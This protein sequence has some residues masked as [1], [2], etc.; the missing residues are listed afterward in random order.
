MSAP[1]ALAPAHAE[2]DTAQFTPRNGRIVGGTPAPNGAYP[3]QVA[4]EIRTSQGASLCGGSVINN[5]TI[6]TAAHCMRAGAT[7]RVLVGTNSL[8]TGGRIIGVRQVRVHPGYNR[9]TAFNNDV[10][11]LRLASPAG[12]VPIR[13]ANAQQVAVLERAGRNAVITGW[14]ATFEGGGAT[15]TLRQ[16][17]V[18]LMS[19]ATCRNLYANRYNITNL[20]I[21]AGR[22]QGGVDTCQGDSG[23]PMVVTEA[24]VRYQIG[25]TSF[26]LG[27]ARPRAPGVYAR[28]SQLLPWINANRFTN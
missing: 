7:Y 6:L 14:G 21:C 24:G 22:I 12:V 3:Y 1:L 27:C 2:P 26:G 17:A 9:P 16:A 5:F 19:L 10:A 28:V 4:V 15:P 11:L 13:L 8:N 18:P 23:G 25:I 20:M